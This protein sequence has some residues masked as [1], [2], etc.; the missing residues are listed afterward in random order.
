MAFSY[1]RSGPK[2]GGEV[3]GKSKYEMLSFVGYI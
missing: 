2:E 1:L 3:R